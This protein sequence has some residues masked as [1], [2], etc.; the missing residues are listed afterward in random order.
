MWY[1]GQEPG[2][3]ITLSKKLKK[4]KSEQSMDFS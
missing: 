1:P 3:E 2:R 4:K